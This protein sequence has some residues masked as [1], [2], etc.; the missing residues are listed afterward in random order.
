MDKGDYQAVKLF[1][2]LSGAF[3]CKDGGA[4][5]EEFKQQVKNIIYAYE[6]GLIGFKE[7]KELL[8]ILYQ[9]RAQ[10]VKD[11]GIKE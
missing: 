5:D 1:R 6:N 10:E 2:I 11:E 8:K 4:E 3:F 7:F 9:K